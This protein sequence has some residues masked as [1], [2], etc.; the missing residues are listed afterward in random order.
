MPVVP[1][2]KRRDDM[3]MKMPIGIICQD[4]PVHPHDLLV[5]GN[6]PGFENRVDPPVLE[7]P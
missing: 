6:D 2:E 7:Y 3:L 4:L 5:L 1:R